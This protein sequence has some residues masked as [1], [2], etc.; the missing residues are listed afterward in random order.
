MRDLLNQVLRYRSF[1]VMGLHAVC[2]LIDDVKRNKGL[3]EVFGCDRPNWGLDAGL[4]D[5]LGMSIATG[6]VIERRNYQREGCFVVYDNSDG[7]SFCEGI[8]QEINDTMRS[9]NGYAE[10][11]IC[12]M[13][14]KKYRE[15]QKT[16]PNLLD[17]RG[18]LKGDVE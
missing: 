12:E 16:L 2:F 7:L 11:N 6:E 1:T 14:D 15:W 8:D 13:A 3:K 18:I 4:G 10:R 5:M 9:L 17:M